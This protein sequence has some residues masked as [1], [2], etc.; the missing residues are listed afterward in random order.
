[1][2]PVSSIHTEQTCYDTL[3]SLLYSSYRTNLL[4][5]VF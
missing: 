4:I 2:H 5:D 1:M 3:T